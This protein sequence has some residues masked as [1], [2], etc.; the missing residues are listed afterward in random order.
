MR[1]NFDG[2]AEDSGDGTDPSPP[3]ARLPTD[4][5]QTKGAVEGEAREK[6]EQ[7]EAARKGEA[8]YVIRY[9]NFVSLAP[10]PLDFKHLEGLVRDA[11]WEL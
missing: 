8:E 9:I 6:K 2:D 5:P 11:T 7:E 10:G 1:S 4:P 3:V